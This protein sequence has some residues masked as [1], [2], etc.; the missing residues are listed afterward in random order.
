MAAAIAKRP[1]GRVTQAFV[2]SAE[3]EGTYRF[4][5]K[6]AIDPKAIGESSHRATAKRRVGLPFVVVALDASSL[7]LPDP[8]G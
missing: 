5:E 7:N 8:T 6:D 3:R 2:T 4:I 1:A